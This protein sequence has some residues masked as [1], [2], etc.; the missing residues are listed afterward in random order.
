MELRYLEIEQDKNKVYL[1]EALLLQVRNNALTQEV[2][3][4]NNV[5]HLFMIVA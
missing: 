4:P 2:R 1:R 5:E 3:S